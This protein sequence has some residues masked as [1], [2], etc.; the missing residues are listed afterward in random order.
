MGP[1]R[2]LT[3]IEYCRLKA[4]T[5]SEM[6]RAAEVDDLDRRALRVAEEDVLGL[7]VAVDD[8]EF[9][10]REEH[11]RH[12]QLL[13]ELARQVERD[14]AKVGVAQQVVEVVREQLEDETEV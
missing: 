12:A 1:I 11:Q 3:D 2:E 9:G 6:A 8:V 14:A 4:Y 13:R 7:E 5:F 10:R